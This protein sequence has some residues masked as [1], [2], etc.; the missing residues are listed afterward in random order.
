MQVKRNLRADDSMSE[1]DGDDGDQESRRRFDLE[2]IATRAKSDDP[3]IRF[4]AIRTAR[5][6][7]SIDRNPPIDEL[8]QFNFLPLLVQCLTLDQY[9]D[10]QFEAAWALTNIASGS[11]HQTQAVADANAVPY[12]L[13]LLRSPHGNVCEQAVWALGNLIGRS[14]LLLLS[15]LVLSTKSR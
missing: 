14:M 4:E 6:L 7:L 12:L 3:T 10:L 13:R 15:N 2:D 9:P 1:G 5:K 11:S 8:I